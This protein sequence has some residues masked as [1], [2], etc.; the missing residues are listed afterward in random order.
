[1]GVTNYF[2]SQNK[3]NYKDLIDFVD[4]TANRN[5]MTKAFCSSSE[6]DLLSI[7]YMKAR[8]NL[9]MCGWIGLFNEL[10]QS[11]DELMFVW[12]MDADIQM[13]NVQMDV[14]SVSVTEHETIRKR[15][16]W[17]VMLYELAIVLKEQQKI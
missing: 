3:E 8:N 16:K 7:E 1:M 4:D 12:Q 15:N 17:D 2:D 10:Q 11:V 14:N 5:V 9:M 6:C 13:D